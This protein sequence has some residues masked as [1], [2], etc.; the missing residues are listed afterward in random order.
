MLFVNRRARK[1]NQQ[2]TSHGH[3]HPRCEGL[4]AKILLTTDL[5]LFNPVQTRLLAEQKI[6]IEQGLLI[7]ESAADNVFV[8]VRLA[9]EQPVMRE[10]YE[11]ALTGLACGNITL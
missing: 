7:V 8:V 3:F 9:P 1:S 2:G 11:A 5:G 6:D 10:R 4:E